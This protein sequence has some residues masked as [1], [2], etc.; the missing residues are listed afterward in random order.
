[1]ETTPY[2][3]I[4]LSIMELLLFQFLTSFLYKLQL[5]DVLAQW[6][7]QDKAVKS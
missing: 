6:F 7:T 4:L 2:M 5:L 3:G 1:M